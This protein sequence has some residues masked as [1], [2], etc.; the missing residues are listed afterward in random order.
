MRPIL[1]LLLYH[2]LCNL[3]G[4]V[5]GAVY[6]LVALF[7]SFDGD[8]RLVVTRGMIWAGAIC[9]ALVTPAL[10]AAARPIAKALDALAAGNA[11]AETLLAPARRR[12]LNLPIV[13]SR[14]STLSWL[15]AAVLLP[16]YLHAHL[17]HID[18]LLLVHAVLAVVLIGSVASAFVFY[19]VEW[20]IGKHALPVLVPDGKVSSIAGAKSASIHFKLTILLLL[21]CVLPVA[22][23][24]FVAWAGVATPSVVLYLGGSFLVFGILQ[25]AAIAASVTTPVHQLSAQMKRVRDGDLHA[26]AR[27]GAKDELG[28]LAEGFNEMVAGLRQGAFV[29]DTFGRY[30]TQE[31]LEE[32]LRGKVDLG[33]EMR[34][35]T[36]VFTDLRDFTALS[37]RLDARE[38]VDF[39]NEYLDLMVNIIVEH[40][41][42]V[43]KFIGDA[44]MAIFGA[45]VAQSDHAERAVS[46]SMAMLQRLDAWNRAR[47][48]KGDPPLAMGIGI[49][50]GPVIAGNIGSA[51]KTEYTVIGDTV[52]T[53]SRIEQLNKELGT[54]L[55]I[56]DD[57]RAL[58]RGS[59]PLRSLPPTTVKGKRAPLKLWAV[60]PGSVP[61]K[62]G[63]RP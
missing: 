53:A 28:E 62:A 48:A 29:K 36:V 27:V 5:Y 51:K 43:D 40:G 21:N 41:G 46:A 13:N 61:A 15:L 24:T 20:Q 10:F 60:S 38:V 56:S 34:H 3:F 33:G 25:G 45:P 50:T 6:T 30:V 35:A 23:L 19:V 55:L 59:F 47:A 42:T 63:G 2:A 31:V 26:A 49:H 57:T 14:L 39:L 4:V 7:P 12:A 22:V 11:P 54:R 52:N 32:I 17:P 44:I 16:L 8:E 18:V 58:L 1:R 9:Y 37:E